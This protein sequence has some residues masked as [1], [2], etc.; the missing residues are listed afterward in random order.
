MLNFE[1]RVPWGSSCHQNKKLNYYMEFNHIEYRQRSKTRTQAKIDDTKHPPV[2]LNKKR[3]IVSTQK[4][5]PH[6]SRN[7]FRQTTNFCSRNHVGLGEAHVKYYLYCTCLKFNTVRIK[8]N[9]K[10]LIGNK[11][12]L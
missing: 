3:T 8:L 6:F 9:L 5:I 2:D 10:Q 1:L 12:S 11:K 7:I 4:R